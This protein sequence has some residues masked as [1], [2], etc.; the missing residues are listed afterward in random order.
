MY[1]FLE[2]AW[3]CTR[4]TTDGGLESQRHDK[5]NAWICA[6]PT[7]QHD[8]ASVLPDKKKEKKR[9]REKQK[10]AYL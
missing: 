8:L 4:R 9:K 1:I 6:L 2:K 3:M 10:D 5:V 7:T